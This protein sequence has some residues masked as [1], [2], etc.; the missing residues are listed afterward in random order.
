MRLRLSCSNF[1]KAE[2][3]K[4]RYEKTEYDKAESY[5]QLCVTLR[6]AETDAC[7]CGA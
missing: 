5:C 4:A 7:N 2:Y 1:D 3:E 6:H